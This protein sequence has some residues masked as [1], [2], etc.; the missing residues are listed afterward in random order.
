MPY[1]F[2][3]DKSK[4]TL[5]LAPVNISRTDFLTADSDPV[6]YNPACKIIKSGNT[7]MFYLSITGITVDSSKKI[8]IGHV[9]SPYRPAGNYAFAS[10]RGSTSPFLEVGT[11][12]IGTD[13]AVEIYIPAGSYSGNLYLA[14]TYIC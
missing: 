7:I 1:A 5:D 4:Y 6:S 9:N 14:G 13:G 12:Y 8:T 10:V 3:D 11:C 2:N